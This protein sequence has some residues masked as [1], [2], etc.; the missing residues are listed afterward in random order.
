MVRNHLS[1]RANKYL[2][3]FRKW[4]HSPYKTSWHHNFAEEQ[5]METLKRATLELGSNNNHPF[6][7]STLIDSFKSYSCDPTPKAY[8]FLIK[9][10]TQHSHFQ[11]IP[12]VLD[13]IENMES[14]ETPEFMLMHLIGFYC[15][16]GMV[17]YALDLFYRIPRF[18]CTPTV[19]S[20][21]LL[22]SLLC[23]RPKW[24]G[25]V[26]N[27]LLKSQHMSVRFEESTFRVLIKALCGMKMVGY[28]VKMMKIMIDDGF[29]LD[30]EICSSIISSMCKQSDLTG[31][32]ALVVWGDMK[33]LGFSPGVMDYT[34]LMRFLVKEGKVM[35][36]FEILNQMKKD[37]IKPDS[38]CYT[39]VMNGTVKEGDYVKLDELF[40]EML[41]LGI[42]PDVYTYNVY[43]NGLCKQN[44]L[45][46]ALKIIASMEDLGCEPNVVTYNTLLGALFMADDLSKVRG[47][48]KEM[49]MKGIE[50]NLHTYRIILDGFVGKDE[51]QEA[52][53][54]LEEMLEKCFYPRS[55]AFDDIIVQMC[56]KGLITEALELMKKNAA[57]NF[58]PGAR[59]WEALLNSTSELSYSQAS[60]SGLLRTQ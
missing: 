52:C 58:I 27:V 34:N 15:H 40:E 25:M 55:S 36:A 24:I 49:R 37:G 10:L 12:P 33:K 45:D 51:I 8:F 4:P 26:P 60:F 18:R 32:D 59:A 21:N 14:F 19:R 50:M 9:T 39:I 30:A 38:V 41:V 13:H 46:D 6:L 23:R 20:L 29:S 11:D 43:I 17:Q 48:V 53:V 42:I 35:D 44:N 7:L 2:R 1:K 16:V 28:A 57:K 47:L 5:A 3:K 31:T 56:R 22:L 54:L